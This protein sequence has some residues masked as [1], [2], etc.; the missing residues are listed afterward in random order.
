MCRLLGVVSATPVS[1]SRAVGERVLTD[2]VE[3]TK[4][5]G[6]GWG[7]AR[8]PSPGHD[9]QVEVSAGSAAEDPHFTA[10]TH[11]HR[12]AASLVHLRWATTGLA[13][14]P[15]N[16]HPFLADRI[17]MAHNGSIKPIEQLDELL[18][19]EIAATLRGSTDSERYFGLI[20]RH[21]A[22]SPDLAEAVRRAVSQLRAVF[23]TASLN[24]LVLGEDQMVAVHAH[25]RSRLPNED[26]EEITAADLPAEHL[27]D[28]F[29]MRWARTH[30]DAVVIASTG[31]GDLD[32][33]QLESESVTAISMHDLSMTTLPLMTPS[34]P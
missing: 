27:E 24:A 34:T 18:T 6:D 12:S 26:I 17:T 8:I 23:P 4:I 5:H 20:R 11:D 25:A 28:Y 15:E 19:P 1:V 31:F 10:V 14:Q 22:S 13:V 9:P 30:Q 2:F 7:I 32:W 16:S 33:R 29:G 3:L 21:R